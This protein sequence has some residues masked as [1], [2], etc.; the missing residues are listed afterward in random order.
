VIFISTNIVKEK[1][2]CTHCELEMETCV[3]VCV[4][5]CVCGEGSLLFGGNIFNKAGVQLYIPN[6]ASACTYQ[7]ANELHPPPCVDCDEAT[8][9]F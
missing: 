9:C 7:N 1:L 5:V 6:S 8:G 2:L 4:C 3:C